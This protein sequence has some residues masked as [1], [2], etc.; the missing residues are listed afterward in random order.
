[1]NVTISLRALVTG[2]VLL[3]ACSFSAGLASEYITEDGTWWQQSVPDEAR[4]FVIA[5]MLNAYRSGWADGAIDNGSRIAGE[6][7]SK[8]TPGNMVSVMAVVYRKDGSGGFASL[9]RVPQFSQTFGYY[10]D[11]ITNFYT[12]HPSKSSTEIG[13]VLTCLSDNLLSSPDTSCK[14]MMAP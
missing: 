3:L 5:A 1:M 10:S 6:L 12:A 7:D 4:P 14:N 13:D 9:D 11:A 2:V 8:L